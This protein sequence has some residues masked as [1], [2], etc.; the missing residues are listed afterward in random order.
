MI[1]SD[2]KE[3]TNYRVFAL[4]DGWLDLQTPTLTHYSM[5]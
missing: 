2:T 5:L 4:Y 3:M 1:N